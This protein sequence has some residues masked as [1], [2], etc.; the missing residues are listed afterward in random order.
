[1]I[2]VKQG[3]LYMNYFPPQSDGKIRLKVQNLGAVKN[4]SLEIKPLTIFIGPNSSGK[5]YMAYL[6]AEMFGFFSYLMYMTQISLKKLIGSYPISIEI[7]NDL[8][9]LNKKEIDIIKTFNDYGPLYFE[10][11]ANYSPKWLPLYFGTEK[12]KFSKLKISVDISD[13]LNE[14]YRNLELL[15]F[16]KM[17][18]S[19][20]KRSSLYAIKK[21]HD[22]MIKFHIK[23]NVNDFSAEEIKKFIIEIMFMCFRKSIFNQI[24]VFGAERTGLSFLFHTEATERSKKEPTI[25]EK[26]DIVELIKGLGVSF[27]VLDLFAEIDLLRESTNSQ[28]NKKPANKKYTELSKILENEI[29]GGTIDFSK[30]KNIKNRK[31]LFNWGIDKKIALEIP[32]VSSNV[33]GIISLVLILKY[34]T[35]QNDLIIIDEPE[36]NLHPEA[37]VKLIEFITMLINANINVIIT[38]HSPYFVDHLVN[39]MK[40]DKSENK[41]ILKEKFFLKNTDSFISQNKVA[42]Y[43]FNKGTVNNILEESGLIDWQTFGD[44]SEYISELYFLI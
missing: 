41:D 11:I 24:R 34:S 38:T 10:Q 31:I 27:P 26:Q 5:T 33:K 35:E 19:Q 16:K 8:I 42:I 17:V 22:R 9:Q 28:K 32:L 1:M 30:A 25:I 29:L 18:K 15:S 44:I 3:D 7:F 39:L 4:A 40:A 21:S 12:E 13:K 2:I 6:I 20:N 14:A 43:L 37:Q 23:N 36:M